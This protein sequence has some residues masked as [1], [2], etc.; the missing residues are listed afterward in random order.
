ME[1]KLSTRLE[2]LSFSTNCYAF[3]CTKKLI[4]LQ[5][6]KFP[7][8]IQ[9]SQERTSQFAKFFHPWLS[10]FMMY[11]S[12]FDNNQSINVSFLPFFIHACKMFHNGHHLPLLLLMGN[13][14]IREIGGLGRWTM[15]G[16]MV[17]CHPPHPQPHIWNPFTYC[18][19]YL[20]SYVTLCDMKINCSLLM[21][22]LRK[23]VGKCLCICNRLFAF[24]AVLFKSL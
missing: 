16:E 12:D 19:L 17:T 23:I 21:C 7:L 10:V 13:L 6:L 18:L 9:I 5:L 20:F 2:K 11:G 4:S 8:N 3:S 22:Y 14:R 24:Q 1:G 15:S